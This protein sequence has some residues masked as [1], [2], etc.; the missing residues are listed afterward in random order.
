LV[1][2]QDKNSSE[3]DSNSSSNNLIETSDPFV[4]ELLNRN[5]IN[6]PS[7]PTS[8]SSSLSVSSHDIGDMLKVVKQSRRR[9]SGLNSVSKWIL[10]K[11]LPSKKIT[12]SI[13][14]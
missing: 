2:G 7:S 14:R 3:I 11:R 5:T 13:K 12:F 6:R 10:K 4:D 8:I 9:P 1:E